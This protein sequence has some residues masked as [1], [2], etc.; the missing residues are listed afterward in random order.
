MILRASLK[1]NCSHS[2]A[3]ER[4]LAML[5]ICFLLLCLVQESVCVV[6]QCRDREIF[7]VLKASNLVRVQENSEDEKN[8]GLSRF[9]PTNTSLFSYNASNAKGDTLS[10]SDSRFLWWL[11]SG[12]RY[13]PKSLSSNVHLFK[14]NSR[15]PHPSR[16][17]PSF[18]MI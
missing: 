13:H 2:C 9:S 10:V 6:I 15:H 11:L 18:A 7:Q 17:S 8:S 12:I 16:T 4:N 3:D 5:N 1:T 14:W